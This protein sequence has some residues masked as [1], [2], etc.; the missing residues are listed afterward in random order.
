MLNSL[1]SIKKALPLKGLEFSAK[2]A[3]H[4]IQ[5]TANCE[6]KNSEI[7]FTLLVCVSRG[8]KEI[9]REEYVSTYK[10][11]KS[12]YVLLS[13]KVNEKIYEMENEEA[14][15][16]SLLAFLKLIKE[17]I[18][19]IKQVHLKK[20]YPVQIKKLT[21]DEYQVSIEGISIHFFYDKGCI[22]LININLPIIGKVKLKRDFI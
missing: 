5:V 19:N 20:V 13:K 15:D 6:S 12:A 22:Y 11:E 18:E 10:E 3:F 4:H 16:I 1:E 9:F 2:K 7:V 21:E 8:S 14:L 17:D